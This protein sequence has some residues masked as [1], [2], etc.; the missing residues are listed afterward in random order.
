[1][2]KKCFYINQPR[3]ATFFVLIFNVRDHSYEWFRMFE[4]GTIQN[5][6]VNQNQNVRTFSRELLELITSNLL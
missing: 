3:L 5:Q 1:M 2:K 4:I 6:N